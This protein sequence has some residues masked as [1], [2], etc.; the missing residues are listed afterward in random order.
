M[1]YKSKTENW[2]HQDEALAF[3]DEHQGGALFMDMGTG[4]SKTVVDWISKMG[5]NWVLIVCPK[6]VIDVW[7]DE[8]I[9]HA[10][11]DWLVVRLDMGAAANAKQVA[12]SLLSPRVVF[13][14]S[15]ESVWRS[16]LDEALLKRNWDAVILDESQKIK[17]P[18]SRVSKFLHTLGRR[19]RHRVILTGT[20]YYNGPLDIYGQFRFLDDKVF[21][22]NFKKFQDKYAI[23]GGFHNYQILGYRNLDDLHAK[24]SAQSFV[25]KS[26]DV[27]VLPEQRHVTYTCRLSAKAA[28]VYKDLKKEMVSELES[29]TITAALAITR[30]LRFQQIA[31]GHLT[32]D[33]GTTIQICDAKE[34]LL[35][36]V[37]EDVGISDP[38]VVFARFSADIEAIKRVLVGS[39]RSFGVLSGNANDLAEWKAGRLNSLV[40][41]I[42]SGGA[43]ID[44][45]RSRYAIYYCPGL[46]LGEYE[47]SVKRIHRPGQ[48]RDVTYI[49]LVA[50]Q[51]IDRDV[52]KAL[53]GK[54]DVV[55]YLLNAL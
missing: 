46:S 44:L 22:T 50:E 6:K 8:F 49:R 39:G 43:G 4:K 12:A 55:R 7:P 1:S 16:P 11:L 24:V 20:P 42:Q 31:G 14:I 52:W 25:V 26:E 48:T 9:T 38:V 2:P 5:L 30:F 35:E 51:T 3:L 53:E 15:Y 33:D 21:G 23:M 18:G 45:T 34:R 13:V 27:Q 54:N 32:L 41:Q 28:K 47:Q 17:S 40:V 36:D 10:G 19:A 37:L 29:G